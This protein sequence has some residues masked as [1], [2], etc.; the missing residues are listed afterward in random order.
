MPLPDQG[1]PAQVGYAP[2]P[3]QFTPQVAPAAPVPN[4]NEQFSVDYLN[5]IATNTP[6]KKASPL[7]I[8]GLIGG[9]LVLAAGLLIFMVQAAAPP[10][11]STQIYALQARLDTLSK[12]TSE[13][14][15]HLTQN[16]LSSINSTLGASLTSTTTDLAAYAK[17]RGIKSGDKA[18]TAAK[19]TEQPYYTALS[20][21]LD[22]AYLLGTLDRTYTTEMQYQ[23]SILKS[24]LQRIKTAANSK[25]FNDFYTPNVA[26]IDTVISSL[27]SFQS[28]K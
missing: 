21:K 25:T 17:L 14:G 13:Q 6:V 12:V 11:V 10:N 27:S 2:Q 24:K 23:L 22:D 3:T 26:S 7:L 16:E 28:T 20:K 8:F 19:T 5:K 9:I 18:A 15:K 4:P 1:Q